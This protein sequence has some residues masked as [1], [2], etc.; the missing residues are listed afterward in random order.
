MDKKKIGSSEPDIIAS[1]HPAFLMRQ[2]DQ[3]TCL[4]RFKAYKKNISFQNKIKW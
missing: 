2:P 3:K 4:G 1:F